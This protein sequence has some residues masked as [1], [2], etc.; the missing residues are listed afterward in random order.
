MR[1]VA[2]DPLVCRVELGTRGPPDSQAHS[3]KVECGDLLV[4]KDSPVLR[5]LMETLVRLELLESFWDS[6]IMI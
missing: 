4:I 3:E 1:L 6:M 2:L 5:D